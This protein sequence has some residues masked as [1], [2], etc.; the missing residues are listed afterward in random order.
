MRWH[1]TPPEQ[2]FARYNAKQPEQGDCKKDSGGKNRL[3]MRDQVI[4]MRRKCAALQNAALEKYGHTTRVD[5]RSLKEQGLRRQ[6]EHHP[7]QARIRGM[8]CEGKAEHLAKR[9]DQT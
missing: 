2:T 5:H 7:G 8:S 4:E 9:Q 6:P 3:E 1:R